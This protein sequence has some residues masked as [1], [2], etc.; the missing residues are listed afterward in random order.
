MEITESE[1]TVKLSR[2][3]LLALQKGLDEL[4]TL[5]NR[6]PDERNGYDLN[7]RMRVNQLKQ[8]IDNTLD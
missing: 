5:T 6:Y 8:M 1:Y 7:S 3:D 4:E 2:A